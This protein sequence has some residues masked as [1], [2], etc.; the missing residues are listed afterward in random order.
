MRGNLKCKNVGAIYRKDVESEA[1]YLAVND[2][3]GLQAA[4]ERDAPLARTLAA[5]PPHPQKSR[6]QTSRRPGGKEIY[7]LGMWQLLT[8]LHGTHAQPSPVLLSS[9]L[10]LHVNMCFVIAICAIAWRQHAQTWT[11]ANRESLFNL[12]GENR[13]TRCQKRNSNGNVGS[14]GCCLADS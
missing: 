12:F 3:A 7:P 1:H 5:L 6:Q 13:P 2:V 10:S 8:P 4:D 14:S 11:H 9:L